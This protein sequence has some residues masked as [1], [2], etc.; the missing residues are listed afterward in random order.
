MTSSRDLEILN[1]DSFEEFFNSVDDEFLIQLAYCYPVHLH[2]L[3][4]YLTLDLQLAQE[5]KK[6][7]ITV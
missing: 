7:L 1:V 3:C 6:K 4:V 5:E 2:W